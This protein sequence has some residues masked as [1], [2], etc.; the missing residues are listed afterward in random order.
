MRK[1]ARVL[2][3]TC[4]LPVLFVVAAPAAA[5]V[6][7]GD[8]SGLIESTQPCTFGELV[9]YYSTAQGGTSG[10]FYGS[11]AAIPAWSNVD[12]Y[13][14]GEL[15][16][17]TVNHA[18]RFDYSGGVLEVREGST[19]LFRGVDGFY[20]AW[21]LHD[22]AIV[23]CVSNCAGRTETVRSI[24]P[25]TSRTAGPETSDR[26]PRAGASTTSSCSWSRCPS[27]ARAPC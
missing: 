16:P 2:L 22:F 27:R 20:G 23:P 12:V 1:A 4:V 7:S 17:L 13:D 11:A 19:V 25:G 15:D 9:T 3:A 14:A 18:E 8:I 26:P 24:S 5:T 6:I 21:V 10:F